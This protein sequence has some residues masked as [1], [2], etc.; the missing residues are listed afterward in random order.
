M[1]IFRRNKPADDAEKM[2]LRT[3]YGALDTFPAE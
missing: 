2:Q 1:P 3:R